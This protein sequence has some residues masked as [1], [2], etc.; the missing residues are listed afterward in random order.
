MRS[1]PPGMLQAFQSVLAGG[2]RHFQIGDQGGFVLI[3]GDPK[4]FATGMNDLRVAG[5]PFSPTLR[6]HR[7][8]KDIVHRILESADRHAIPPP[9]LLAGNRQRIHPGIRM[10]QDAG[11]GHR[12][13]PRQ[14]GV[15][16]LV[17]NE[18]RGRDAIEFEER[19]ILTG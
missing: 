9:T 13:D 6:A 10:E 16:P 18:G 8:G 5:G 14:F 15:P 2:V 11:T 1:Q 19:N 4:H 3:V 7:I 17:A 12:G